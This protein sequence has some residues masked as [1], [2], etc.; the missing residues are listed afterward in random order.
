MDINQT[1]FNSILNLYPEF[2]RPNILST[3]TYLKKKKNKNNCSKIMI[4]TNNQ[5]SKEWV[6]LIKNYFEDLLQFKLFDQIIAAFKINGKTLEICRSSHYKS[7][8]DLIKCTK[9]PMNTEI[10]FID[11]SFHPHMKNDNVYY[12]N[13][14]PYIYDLKLNEMLKRLK[15]SDIIPLSININ[16]D[17]LE[18]FIENYMIDFDFTYLPKQ[19]I[20]LE[21]DNKIS[22][23]ILKHLHIFFKITKNIT[24]KYVKNNNKYHSKTLKVKYF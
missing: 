5:G 19:S 7:H 10:C 13:I 14:K 20:D 24:K 6:E 1:L 22:R 12:I 3:L 23:K 8:R 18:L 16:Y 21:I 17:D 2:L 15:E 11:D 4:Y 9:I